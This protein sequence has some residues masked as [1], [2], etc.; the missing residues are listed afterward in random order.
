MPSSTRTAR[1]AADAVG[2]EVACIVKSLAFRGPDDA[3]VLVLAA[4]DARVNED[5]LTHR[6]GGVVRLA[7][8]DVVREA[9]GFAIGGVAPVGLATPVPILM[10]QVLLRHDRVWAAAGTPRSVFPIDPRVLQRVTG[11]DVIDVRGDS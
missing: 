2:C 1:D 5:V 7:E 8:P 3:V 4:G 11:A 6:L 10:D 9:T